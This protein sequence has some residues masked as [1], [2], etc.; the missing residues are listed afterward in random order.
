MAFMNEKIIRKKNAIVFI[1]ILGIVFLSLIIYILYQGS[2][3]KKNGCNEMAVKGGSYCEQHT[4]EVEGC[5]EYK[6]G[7]SNVCEIHHQENIDKLKDDDTIQK[8]EE[9]LR[10]KYGDDI[11]SDE[12]IMPK[13]K[14]SGCD[15]DGTGTYGGKWYC[16]K[17]LYE[18]KNYGK[19]ISN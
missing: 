18:M 8:L 17:H 19:I 6:N 1:V 3:C 13:C 15:E 2:I 7:W 5:Y 14:Y 11:F 4:C 9:E 12:I 10:E 16:S